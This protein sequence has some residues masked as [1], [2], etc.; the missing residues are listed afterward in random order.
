VEKGEKQAMTR[1]SWCVTKLM[2]PTIA[3]QWP[4]KQTTTLNMTKTVDALKEETS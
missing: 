4:N 3:R 2:I 1:R